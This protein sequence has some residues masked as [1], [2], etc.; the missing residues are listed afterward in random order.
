MEEHRATT[1]AEAIDDDTIFIRNAERGEAVLQTDFV[2][3]TVLII[4]LGD[5]GI[6]AHEGI[7]QGKR[8]THMFAH[9]IFHQV[10]MLQTY[11]IP[12]CVQP[13]K[14]MLRDKDAPMHAS[15]AAHGNHQ[16]ALSL[17]D[18]LGHQKIYHRIQDLLEF[19]RR[20]LFVD[21]GR[22]LRHR[23]AL[24][25]HGFHIERVRQK[26]HIQHHIRIQRHAEL[27]AEGQDIDV[28]LFAFRAAENLDDLVLEFC[29]FEFRG[30]NDIGCFAANGSQSL[31]F[32]RNSFRNA[33][34]RRHRMAASRLFVAADNHGIRR[35]H[36]K[37]FIGLIAL[38]HILQHMQEGIKKLAAAGIHHQYDLAHMTSHMGAKLRKLRD[39]DRRQ[40]VHAE[41]SQILHI[42][43]S[44]RLS[45]A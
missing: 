44:L 4:K 23:A 13:I 39:K 33:R 9:V 5:Q 3:A 18:I 16:L 21:I 30:I 12:L 36:E 26:P 29:L 34:G 10:P 31:P 6:V 11:R 8:L 43:A 19:L 25:A 32:L 41:I 35:I 2:V 14:N 22:N 40:I 15:R 20:R 28:H 37:H 27:E 7:E 38:V 17:F 1:I 45:S 24:V 42:T